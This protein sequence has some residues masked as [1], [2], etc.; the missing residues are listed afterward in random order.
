MSP[1]TIKRQV[2]DYVRESSEDMLY[3][4]QRRARE[5]PLQAVVMAKN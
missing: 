3:S 5:N 2:K 4:L 1:A